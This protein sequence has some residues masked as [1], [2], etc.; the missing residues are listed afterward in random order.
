MGGITSK[1]RVWQRAQVVLKPIE[2]PKEYFNHRIRR[3][4]Y[5]GQVILQDVT[6]AP[7]ASY[8]AAEGAGVLLLRDQ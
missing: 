2:I 3:E 5:S 6:E 8:S 7:T 4:P 1:H